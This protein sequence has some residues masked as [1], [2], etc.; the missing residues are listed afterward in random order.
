[1]L[2]VQKKNPEA[3]KYAQRAYAGRLK[4][5]GWD[6]EN[7]QEANELVERLTKPETKA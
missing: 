5:L 2:E 1:M 7:T 3:L 6:H 4:V